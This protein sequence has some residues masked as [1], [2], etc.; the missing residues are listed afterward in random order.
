MYA[1]TRVGNGARGFFAECPVTLRIEV[2]RRPFTMRALPTFAYIARSADGRR[3]KGHADAVSESAVL[4]DLASRGLSPISVAHSDHR[5][6]ERRVGVRPLAS[7]YRQLSELLRSGVPLLR[8]IRLLARGKSNVTLARCWGEVAEALAGGERLADAMSKHERTFAPVHVAMVRAGERGAFLEPV[9]ARLATLLEQQA[10]LRGRVIG[11]MLYPAVLLMVGAGVVLASLVF[12]VPKFEE[13][14]SKMPSL[15][16]PTRI[17]LASSA[18]VTGNV[19]L[20]VVLVMLVIAGIVWAA[21]SDRV[22]LELLRRAMKLPYLG[23]LFSAIAVARF[24]RMLGTLLENGIPMLQA[25]DIA[26]DSAGNPILADAIS[27]A[28]TAVKHG[29]TL[30]KP[31]EECGLFPED[32]LEMISVGESSNNLPSVLVRLADTLESRIDRMLAMMLRLMEPAMLLVI[33]VVVMFIF[34]ALVV[35]MMQLSSQ[36]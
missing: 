33:A 2:R 32:V 15:P 4:T 6:K 1:A 34:L 31:L 24:A 16:M 3:V 9:L 25:L 28:A 27:R 35:P 13:F 29:E 8:A 10:D 26:R 18:L 23:S 30:S 19:W 20:T 36:L 11:N 12:F 21:R 5:R 17:L 7:S 14:F 22:R